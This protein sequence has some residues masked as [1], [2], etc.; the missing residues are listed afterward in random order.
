MSNA[1]PRIGELLLD[2]GLIS[3]DDV[4]RA[5]KV[6]SSVNARF[7]SALIKLGAIS[8]DHLL[9]VLAEQLGVR[10]LVESDIPAATELYQYMISQ[11]E[12]FEWFLTQEVVIWEGADAPGRLFCIA[13]DFIDPLVAETLQHF[14][15]ALEIEFCLTSGYLL[16]RVLNDLHR[17][18]SV[19]SLFQNSDDARQLRELAEEAP[20]VEFVNNV[21]AQAV[22]VN[23]SDIHIE[24]QE[25]VFNIRFR[26]DGVLHNRLIQP[27]ERFAAVASR[28]KLVAGLDIAERR[29]PQDGR[30]TTRMGGAEMDVRVSTVPCVQGE[31]IV[32]RLLPKERESLT[33][34]NLGMEPDHLAMMRR[35][36]ASSGGIVLVTGPTGSGKSTTLHAA[37]SDSNDGVRKII[38]VEDPVEFRVPGITQIQAH[39]EIGYTFARALRAIL[40]Q[41]PDVIMIGEIRDLETA[42]IAIQSALSGHLVL[43]TLHT[44]DAVSSFTRLIDMGI[45]PFLVAA[46]LKGVQAQRLVRKVCPSCAVAETPAK[47]ILDHLRDLPAGL[48]SNNWVRAVGCPACQNTG[49]SGR[50]GIYQLVEVDQSLQDMIVS[51]AT[52]NAIKRHVAAAGSR[53]LLQDGL[54][55]ASRSLTTVDEVYRVITAE[56]NL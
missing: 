1:A 22:D 17:E 42:E 32:M 29:L 39:A 49:Y 14:H 56:E 34:A 33:L 53:N 16:E 30:M 31:S 40:R 48:S 54:I 28:I 41:D 8:D 15:P 2:R 37:L 45:E 52:L 47:E 7:G 3:R 11:R 5:L 23:A 9:S 6:Q 44:N 4:D 21:M 46:P 38:T 12:N 13:R 10:R 27:I 35:W 36:A 50:I 25:K 51:G 43:S 55:K 26:I 20:V 19:D 24:P 18:H